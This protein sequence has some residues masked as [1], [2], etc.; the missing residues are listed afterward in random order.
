M[1]SN[2]GWPLGFVPTPTE[3]NAEFASKSDAVLSSAVTANFNVV[4]LSS[5]L[6][7][8]YCDPTSNTITG[9]LPNTGMQ[10]NNAYQLRDATGQAGTHSISLNGNGNNIN[11]VSGTSVVIGIAYGFATA[12]WSGTQWL[13]S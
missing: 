3:W 4:Q 12:T 1:G 5:P 10:V 6:T 7:I 8:F 11:G 13:L 2:P 9:L